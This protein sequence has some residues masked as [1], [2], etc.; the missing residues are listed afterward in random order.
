MTHVIARRF[1]T[2]GKREEKD[3]HDSPV[4]T[5]KES[6][7]PSDAP[8]GG[9]ISPIPA[10]Q[11]TSEGVGRKPDSSIGVS[12]LSGAH[13]N[14]PRIPA[15]RYPS[16]FP[17]SLG[18]RSF[19]VKF[20][21]NE[22]L[23]GE[24]I[25]LDVETE[26]IE[27]P[28]IPEL[29]LLAAS[30][31]LGAFLVRPSDVRAFLNVH[32]DR[33]LVFH[34][35]AFDFWVLN[36]YLGGMGEQPVSD[37]LWAA[38]DSNRVHDTMYLDMLVHLARGGQ[39]GKPRSLDKLAA[40]WAGVPGLDKD[41]PYRM[42]FG[43][44]IGKAWEEVDFGFFDYAAPDAVATA[45]I[46]GP[47]RRA[48][49]DISLAHRDQWAQ[50]APEES[51]LLSESIQVKAAIAFAAVERTGIGCDPHAV[52]AIGDMLQKQIDTGAAALSRLTGGKI[53][54]L[55]QEGKI[56]I[57]SQGKPRIV[58]RA[59][60]SCLETQLREIDESAY[61]EFPRTS[62]KLLRIK[63]DLWL[64]YEQKSE[65]VSEWLRMEEA[66]KRKGF[67][68]LLLSERIHSRYGVLTRTGRTTCSAPNIQQMPREGRFRECFKPRSGCRFVILDWSYI[69]LVALAAICVHR[70]G[71]SAL[72]DIIRSGAD[73][74]C[75][76]AALVSEM[77][78]PDFMQLEVQDPKLY[79]E[80]RQKAK[81]LNFGIPAGLGATTLVEHAR[82]DFGVEMSDAEAES[83]RKR[84]IGEI[85]PELN[86]YLSGGTCEALARRLRCQPE[87]LARTV[88]PTGDNRQ[89][90]FHAVAR[91]LRGE[92][93]RD[94]SP[95]SSLF[96]DGVW[97]ALVECCQNDELLPLLLSRGPKAET[98]R[99]CLEDAT[100]LT[101]RVRGYAQYTEARNT[102]FQGLTSD[103]AK[104]ACYD[105]MRQGFSVVAFIHDEFVVEIEQ[106]P[107]ME[108][109]AQHIEQIA[110][111][112]MR[113]VLYCDLPVRAR[114]RIS[115]QWGA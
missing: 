56:E 81:A 50:G 89:W 23:Q 107:D 7:T 6:P 82:K 98:G 61:E 45:L 53:F 32:L 40:E 67:T 12:D 78:L 36:Q 108:R 49:R 4:P 43:E 93:K 31:G 80:M 5:T 8:P 74:H 48:A 103:G 90:I 85:Y 24:V 52:Q 112:A 97:A 9:P 42:R 73:P 22:V 105:L 51:G 86:L 62:K 83:F 44:I 2:A 58:Q 68:R 71:R 88:D 66:A 46:Y 30:N 35:A 113:S 34:N 29:A 70:Y 72:A 54:K 25:A 20:W 79:R 101:G 17:I 27:G 1:G 15:R 19:E 102:P 38:A 16:P 109:H 95:Y 91:I 99:L 69:E 100:T 114:T 87:K 10:A 64:P 37:A 59:L 94:G 3:R 26:V 106:G 65:F 11:G 13:E 96:E 60:N 84:V 77:D 21:T 18:G 104:L 57:T 75:N 110:C 47:L 111:D 63:R 41:N 39:G 55:S 115:H 28:G 92:A 14:S 76:T 33:D